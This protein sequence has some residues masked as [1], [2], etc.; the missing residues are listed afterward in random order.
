MYGA[1]GVGK[2]RYARHLAGELPFY[3]KMCNKW[4][5]GYRGES[6]VV[7]DDIGKEHSVLGHH[8]KL[9]A[10]RYGF[11]GETKNGAITPDYDRFIVTSQY[12][13]E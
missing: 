11:I 8:L 3:R 9:W 1:S 6:I 2:S 4:W 10:D 7:M 13:P 12:S 5:D